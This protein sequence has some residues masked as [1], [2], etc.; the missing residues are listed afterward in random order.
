MRFKWKFL[1]FLKINTNNFFGGIES[2]WKT[3]KKTNFLETGENIRETLY[4][5]INSDI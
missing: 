4:E 1:I 5:S 2:L 3:E